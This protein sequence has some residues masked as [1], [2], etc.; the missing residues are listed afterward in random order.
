MFVISMNSEVATGLYIH[1]VMT[2][3]PGTAALAGEANAT[4]TMLDAA[5]VSTVERIRIRWLCMSGVSS[6]PR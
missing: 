3:C 5:S 2:I 6:E 1:S 4:A